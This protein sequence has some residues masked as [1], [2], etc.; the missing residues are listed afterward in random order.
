MPLL[1]FLLFEEKE[2]VTTYIDGRKTFS[3]LIPPEYF[4]IF[5][6]LDRKLL[7]NSYYD[8]GLNYMFNCDSKILKIFVQEFIKFD[9]RNTD[10]QGIF[11]F[12][13]DIVESFEILR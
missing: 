13:K 7:K 11:Y 5:N 4:N 12:D 3:H 2:K 1:I 9:C 10:E 8:I 6:E